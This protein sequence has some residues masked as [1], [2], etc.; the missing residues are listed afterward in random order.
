MAK[1]KK[2]KA[3]LTEAERGASKRKE[4]TCKIM[5]TQQRPRERISL[6]KPPS[7]ALSELQGTKSGVLPCGGLR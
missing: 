7:S 5:F 4:D 3:L 6:V 2:P 1:H